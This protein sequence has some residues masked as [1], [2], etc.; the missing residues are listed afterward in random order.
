MP[1]PP[2][3][4]SI[5]PMA[6]CNATKER[7]V[8]SIKTK[9]CWR[10]SELTLLAKKRQSKTAVVFKYDGTILCAEGSGIKLDEMANELTR[11][12]ITIFSQEKATDGLMRL[13]HRRRKCLRDCVFRPSKALDLGFSYLITPQTAPSIVGE[14][15]SKKKA[16]DPVPARC[17]LH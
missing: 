10:V 13:V 11:A 14:Q 12:G 17:E 1:W 16:L 5:A 8:L 2:I 4:V 7:P 9:P 15:A 3:F 6:V